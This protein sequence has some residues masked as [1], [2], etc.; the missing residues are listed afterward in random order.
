MNM[1]A[2]TPEELRACIAADAQTSPSTYL[3][4]DSFAAWCYD[5]LSL[6]EVRSAFER[7]ADPDECEQ[8]QL[9]PL[10]W[11]TQVEMALIA[12]TAAARMNA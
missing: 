10:E 11:K 7:D 2:S 4:D 1:P 12:L 8:W 5:H 6:S 9:T 3:A